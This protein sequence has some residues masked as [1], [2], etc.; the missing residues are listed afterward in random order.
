MHNYDFYNI[1]AFAP[2]EFQQFAC[3]LMSIREEKEFQRFGVGK[4]GG[5][6]GQY[7]T[8]DGNIIL[9]VKN[10]KANGRALVK[11]VRK[12]IQK[13]EKRHCM[14]KRYII[15]FSTPTI[16]PMVKEEIKKLCP[17]ILN[18]NDI[19]SAADINAMLDEEKY[20]HLEK[21]YPQLWFGNGTFLE[22]MLSKNAVSE[23]EK[24]GRVARKRME[25]E[26][27]ERKFVVTQK[28]TQA[29]ELLEMYGGLIISGDPGVGKTAHAYCLALYYLKAKEYKKF[30]IAKSL[31][32][33]ERIMGENI[34]E[35]TIIL[36]DDFWG[37]SSF[38]VSH[39]EHNGDNTLRDIFTVLK[40]YPQIR[41][42][43]TTREFVLQQGLR[44]YPELGS[45][46]FALQRLSINLKSYTKAEKAE[47][48]FKH[49]E[50]SK[51]E[52]DYVVA[53]YEKRENII[54]CE[55]YSP[56]SVDYY[57]KNH[58]P[59]DKEPY[60]YAKDF[61]NY[62]RKPQEFYEQ[63]YRKISDGAKW[64]CLLLVLSEDEIR[65]NDEL[66][67]G[68]MKIADYLQKRVD[69]ELYADYLKELDST[70][71]K[72]DEVDGEIVLDFLNYSIRDYMREYLK[73]NISA[74]EDV[75]VK[76]LIYYNQLFYLVSEFPVSEENRNVV[77]MRMM[78][79]RKKMKFSYWENMDVDFYYKVDATADA[80]DEHKLWLLYRLYRIYG[81]TSLR[82]YLYNYCDE[83]VEKMKTE[84][85]TRE[86][87]EG[88]VNLFPEIVR[89]GYK[90]DIRELLEL[91]YKN[92]RWVKEIENMQ[93]LKKMSEDIYDEF[94]KEHMEAL[95]ERIKELIY[96]D[97]DY[98]MDEPDGDARIENMLLGLP[99]LLAHY[100]IPYTPEEEEDIKEYAEIYYPCD[101]KEWKA[102]LKESAE[103]MK[104]WRKEER[105]EKIAYEA[106]EKEGKHQLQLEEIYLNSSEIKKMEYENG[107]DYRRSYITKGK[108]TYEDFL[109]VMKYLHGLPQ[110]P[111]KEEI[112][113]QG[114]TEYLISDD[115]KIKY[116]C[117]LAKE[118]ID[119]QIYAFSI[120]TLEKLSDDVREKV[121]L[122]E[123]VEKGILRY[124]GKWYSFG[125]S[126]YMY[127]LAY[128]YIQELTQEELQSY[129]HNPEFLNKFCEPKDLGYGWLTFL[130][131]N[132]WENFR[133]YVVVPVLK[134][135]QKKL[136]NGEKEKQIIKFLEM[137][138]F[139]IMLKYKIGER[140]NVG[141]IYFESVEIA[142]LELLNMELMDE[143]LDD[144]ATALESQAPK[145]SEQ[146]IRHIYLQDFLQSK[147]GIGILKQYGCFDAANAIL[148]EIKRLIEAEDYII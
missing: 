124:S 127:Y 7:E 79:N 74:Y 82:D 88:V 52:Y 112:F 71:T 116:L 106:V 84:D 147:R 75:L 83:L 122:T 102:Y 28:F 51:L 48:L 40:E 148:E 68:F 46:K 92:I 80:Y 57:L 41:I 14:C 66:K 78:E 18:T 42:I 15:V 49:L 121:N 87:M 69:K 37:H 90:V 4:D 50:Y 63:I 77:L 30:Y 1:F 6:D 13:I 56:R 9:Q 5:I 17:D 33:I 64:I 133:Q 47:I 95:R 45:E 11:M 99:E 24:S 38:E 54:N 137:L 98:Y 144:C 140:Q 103:A 23:I 16:S 104:K 62:V 118:L 89:C 31:R 60:E 101:N 105:E 20:E 61:E 25:M 55:A 8:E 91:Y 85:I 81:P 126:R 145:I 141:N 76:G 26:E 131:E 107:V 109:L 135:Y 93:F 100:E 138:E 39:E 70:F 34:E 139:E 86:E 143:L 117:M 113:Y 59:V 115:D 136:G 29:V 19:L 12:E 44:Y 3:A 2:L 21:A 110:V 142:I 32:E 43:L 120:H 130:Y 58:L 132:D 125:N 22:E 119:Q 53:I 96:E 65:V 72:I 111:K 97:I 10:T 35:R 94:E 27:I 129:Y 128:E 114:L 73:C 108:F 146:E 36:Y 134:E 67:Y 123:Y